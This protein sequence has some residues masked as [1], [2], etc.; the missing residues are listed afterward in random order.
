MYLTEIA[1][2]HLRGMIGSVNQLVIVTAILMSQI[3]GL[4]QLLGTA[5]LWP[6]LLGRS[7]FPESSRVFEGLFF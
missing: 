3:L 7:L 6:V 1:P 5:T 2:L 4:P